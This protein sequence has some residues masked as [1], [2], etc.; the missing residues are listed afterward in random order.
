MNAEAKADVME[1]SV[2]RIVYDSTLTVQERCAELRALE[3]SAR[4]EAPVDY[5]LAFEAGVA[6]LAFEA[7]ARAAFTQV[8]MA[9]P[10][11]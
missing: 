8:R 1:R 4:E 7:G 5:D 9:V 11:V 3:K 2:W 10:F 6:V